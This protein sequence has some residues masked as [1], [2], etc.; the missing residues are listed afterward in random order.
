MKKI[1][2]ILFL[3]MATTSFA[4]LPNTDIWVMDMQ[5][6]NDTVI[7][8]NPENITN[9]VGYDNQPVFSP[10]SKYLLYTSVRDGLQSDVFKYDVNTKVTSQVTKT[11]TSEYSPKFM[12]DGKNISVVMVEADST[13]RIWSFPIKGGRPKVLI[14]KID[15]VAY[16]CWNNET[17]IYLSLITKPAQLIAVDLNKGTSTPVMQSIGR[18]INV[19]D[20]PDGRRVYYSNDDQLYSTSCTTNSDKRAETVLG[21]D[22]EDFAFLNANQVIIGDDFR[23]YCKTDF[24]KT[25]NQLWKPMA[26]LSN[27]NIKTITRIAISPDGEKIAIVAESNR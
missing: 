6:K 18:S 7:L 24:N 11:P 16:Y 22:S 5:V 10:D 15:S 4:Q 20:A 26:D 8:V 1:S 23:L 17:S 12:P 9:L 19:L 21:F 2:C 25:G 27:K 14:P 13:Q 3:A